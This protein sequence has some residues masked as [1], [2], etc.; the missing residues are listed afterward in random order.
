MK[1]KKDDRKKWILIA[2]A[3]ILIVFVVLVIA[4]N[5]TQFVW[6]LQVEKPAVYLY[7]ETDSHIQVTIDTAGRIIEDIPEYNGGWNV[8]VTTEGLIEQKYDYLFYEV[9][10][11]SIDLPEQGWVVSQDELNGWFDTNLIAMGMNQKEKDQFKEYWLERLEGSAYYEIKLLDDTF[12]EE[13]MNLIIDPQPDT[14]IRLDFH[15]RRLDNT[16][17]IEEPEIMT[18]ERNGFIVVEWGGILEN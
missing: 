18:P 10:L 2:L 13:N 8:F 16:I 11:N 6:E 4:E 3:I 14:I 1:K 7:P 15:F 5:E 9:Q 17:E 12:L